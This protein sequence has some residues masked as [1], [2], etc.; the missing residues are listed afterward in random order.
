MVIL[1]F[2]LLIIGSVIVQN[3]TAVY[4]ANIN[5]SSIYISVTSAILGVVLVQVLHA[6]YSPVA[7][8]LNNR[9]NHQT[10]TDYDDNLIVKQWLF[11][12]VN[13]FSRLFYY[14]FVRQDHGELFDSRNFIVTCI[15]SC[16]TDLFIQV[17]FQFFADTFTGRVNEYLLP[18]F[19]KIYNEISAKK[20]AKRFTVHPLQRGKSGSLD[21]I[22]KLP[23]YYTDEKLPPAEGADADYLQKIVQFAVLTGFSVVFPLAP[24]FSLLSNS[25]EI[26]TDVYK[27]IALH[28]RAPPIQAQDIGTWYAI[29]KF[30]SVLAVSVNAGIIIFCFETFNDTFLIPF[31]SP[32]S[33]TTVKLAYFVL[34]HIVIHG[35]NFIIA[36]VVPDVP[37][38]V[39][40]AFK[41]QGYLEKLRGEQNENEFKKKIMENKTEVIITPQILEEIK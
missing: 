36:Y 20:R 34:W 3:T 26:H 2:M 29:L 40:V 17:T 14:A 16:S 24:L 30:H 4:M 12:F 23:Q 27:Y 22:K 38:I 32:A 1:F 10:N 6:M 31:W 37:E 13:I 9:E 39:R 21:N 5:I 8:I 25:I 7:V 11:N 41:R 18:W 33:Y 19:Q 28:Q 15:G 35:F